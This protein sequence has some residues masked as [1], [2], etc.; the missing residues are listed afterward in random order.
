MEHI[1]QLFIELFGMI[2]RKTT[3]W[4]KCEF[5]YIQFV[6]SIKKVHP[7]KWKTLTQFECYFLHLIE[8]ERLRY[9]I[10]TVIAVLDVHLSPL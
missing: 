10:L 8:M 7:N 3:S 4:I 1:S 6:W 9:K 2:R 5:R